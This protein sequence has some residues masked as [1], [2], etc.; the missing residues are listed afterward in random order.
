MPHQP[1]R[2]DVFFADLLDD[3]VDDVL[4]VLVVHGRPRP[5]RGVWGGDDQPVFVLIVH[6]R[7]IV[8]LP[9]PVRAEAVQ[10]EDEGDFL[11]LLQVTWIIEKVGA[12]GLHLDHVSLIDYQGPCALAVWTMQIRSCGADRAGQPERLFFLGTRHSRK[13]QDGAHG[14]QSNQIQ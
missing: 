6:D 1:E 7:E 14:Q 5:R 12:A 8:A 9:V 13:H 11:A 2:L 10:A 3:E 4:Q